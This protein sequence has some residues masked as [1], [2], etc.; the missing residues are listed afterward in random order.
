MT[1]PFSICATGSNELCFS[2]NSLLGITGFPFATMA[3]AKREQGHMFC[4]PSALADFNAG[5]DPS[6]GA[7]LTLLGQPLSERESL[8][9]TSL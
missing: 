7:G 3:G 2:L 6:V 4:D 9:F 5:K 8:K 1:R